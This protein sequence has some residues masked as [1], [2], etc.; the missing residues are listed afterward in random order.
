M[1]ALGFDFGLSFVGVAVADAQTKAVKPEGSLLAQKG[2]VA[3]AQLDP[4]IARWKP[5]TL[6]VGNPLN[7]DGS[8]GA[9][10]AQVKAF[11]KKLKKRYH[12]PVVW[13]DERLST[14][15][16]KDRTFQSSGYKGLGQQNMHA[17]SACIMLEQWL[18][19]EE[20]G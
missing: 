16:A 7:M 15:E 1:V 12:L 6:I 13:V 19:V 14:C 18:F 4:L 20:Q 3:W 11:A 9:L 10:D 17:L 5:Q 2:R 8:C